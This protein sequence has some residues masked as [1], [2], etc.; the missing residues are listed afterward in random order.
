MEGFDG[1]LYL[2]RRG[3]QML[4]TPEA[5]H[6][7]AGRLAGQARVLVLAGAAD[8]SLAQV[9]V[10]DYAR[11]GAVRGRGP[12][13]FPRPGKRAA[14]ATPASHR[15]VAC[16]ATIRQPWGVLEVRYAILS[17][18]HTKL[19]IVM[20][21]PGSRPR[22]GSG[23]RSVAHYGASSQPTVAVTDD[24]G[25]TGM[26]TFSGGGSDS[27]WRGYYDIRPAL[28]PRTKWIELLG[29]RVPLGPEAEERAVTVSTF[30]ET[31]LIDRCLDRCLAPD[32]HGQ[33]GPSLD[34][35]VDAFLAAGLLQ[36]DDPRI[37]ESRTIRDALANPSGGAATTQA[38]LREPWRSLIARRGRKDGPAGTLVIGAVTP[39]FDGIS[40]ALL[41]LE[42]GDA[43]FTCEFELVGTVVM[44]VHDPSVSGATLTYAATDD[45]GNHYVGAPGG[46]SGGNDSVAGTLE[47]SP[48]LDPQ[49]RRLDLTF[50][51]DRAQ[52]TVTVPLT[53]DAP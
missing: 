20:R 46:W 27:E 8:E 23:F 29:E 50:T 2:R 6:L 48:A 33:R 7:I 12:G 36:P 52:A 43:G 45:R 24:G 28:A 1:E 17:E 3:E 42:S 37:T 30:D 21:F 44:S 9:V 39:V 14:I 34:E 51:T 22:R 41:Q 5:S 38:G 16:G 25:T 49:A 11:A 31:E 26:A 53:W 13:F 47:F 40:V 35:A 15:V 32:P 18:T 19:A 4:R 10:D